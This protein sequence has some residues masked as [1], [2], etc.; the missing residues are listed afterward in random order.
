MTETLQGIISYPITPFTEAGRV[1]E[2]L[3]AEIVDKMVEAGVHALAPLGSTGVLPYLN[4]Q[5]RETVAAVVIETGQAAR[6]DTRRRVEL[7]HRPH[8]SSRAL[9]REARGRAQ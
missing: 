1:D 4:D 2:K 6:A 8:H 7:D 9:R 3:L 5:E